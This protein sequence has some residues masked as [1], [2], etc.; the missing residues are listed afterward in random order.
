MNVV[1]VLIANS[2]QNIFTTVE[3]RAGHVPADI[4]YRVR[5]NEALKKRD[6]QKSVG[7]TP[8][9]SGQPWVAFP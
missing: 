2:R 1:Y 9:G 8:L 7:E 4:L 5:G 3:R 6:D